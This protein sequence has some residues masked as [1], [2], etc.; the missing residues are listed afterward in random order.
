MV[1]LHVYDPLGSPLLSTL[2]AMLPLVVLLG[3]LA[4]AG[5]SAQWAAVAGLATAFVIAVG[6]V[7]MPADAAIAAAL[8]GAAFGLFP[9]GWIIL[10]AMFLY[11][12]SVEAGSL[13]IIKRSVIRLSPDHRVQALLIAFSFGA[14]LE[15]AAGFGAPVAISAALLTGA[16]F[17]PLEAACLS[18]MA[19]TAP[20]FL[21]DCACVD[22][23]HDGWLAWTH[24]RLAGGACLRCIICDRA[25]MDG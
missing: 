2:V 7:G 15:G 13:E 24:G 3:L 21:T 10:G 8:Y 11:S 23:L 20:F 22:G 17:P 14:F 5:W 12:L 25:S 18:L 1:W 9:I 6:I 16:G 19:N 4:A